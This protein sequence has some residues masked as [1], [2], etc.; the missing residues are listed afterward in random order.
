[1]RSAISPRL[2]MRTLVKMVY[3]LYPLSAI[4]FEKHRSVFDRLAVASSD[5]QDPPR[6]VTTHRVTDAECF[7][8][9]QLPIAFE[10]IAFR[11]RR[12]AQMEDTHQVGSDL[13][14]PDRVRLQGPQ[15]VGDLR[16]QVGVKGPPPEFDLLAATFD[17]QP[18]EIGFH[19]QLGQGTNAP[20]DRGEGVLVGHR[21]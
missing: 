10:Q 14:G 5:C 6:P 15:V 1:M 17:S 20:G 12:P 3:F 8:E 9:G 7:D 19:K 2:A 11:R 4:D 13:I 21:R 16:N 18:E